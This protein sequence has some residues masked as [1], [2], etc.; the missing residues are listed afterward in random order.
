MK[1]KK[2]ALG[3]FLSGGLLGSIVL[4]NSDKK[5]LPFADIFPSN[6]VIKTSDIDDINVRMGYEDI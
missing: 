5:P 4:I 2:L 1:K 6:N 3:G